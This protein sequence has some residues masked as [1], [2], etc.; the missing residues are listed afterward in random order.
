LAYQLK[1][2]SYVTREVS[3]IDKTLT[4]D[5]LW[6]KV[7]NEWSQTESLPQGLTGAI[8]RREVAV[9]VRGASQE[10]AIAAMQAN[11]S[12]WRS[13]PVTV[14]VIDQDTGDILAFG[15]WQKP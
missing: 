8:K 13:A 9:L 3:A 10:D 15:T 12:E 11:A 14:S 4:A 2:G 1:D 7:N 5:R 6:S